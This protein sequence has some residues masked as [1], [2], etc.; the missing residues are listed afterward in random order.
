[1]QPTLTLAPTIQAPKPPPF[2]KV[3]GRTFPVEAFYLEDL[4][5]ATDHLIEAGSYC[6]R[7]M[8]PSRELDKVAMNITNRKGERRRQFVT[9]D[10]DGFDETYIKAQST[11][12]DYKN[13]TRIS[14]GRV[15]GKLGLYRGISSWRICHF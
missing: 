3:P 10:S 9:V 14:M 6:S 7:Q 15:N 8:D 12:K 13:S 1:M 5:D 11:Y 2:I 4:I